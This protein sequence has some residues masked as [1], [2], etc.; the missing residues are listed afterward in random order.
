M[1]KK[2][3]GLFDRILIQALFLLLGLGIAQHSVSKVEFAEPQP[4]YIVDV[5][6]NLDRSDSET[7]RP[8]L[9]SAIPEWQVIDLEAPYCNMSRERFVPAFGD[10]PARIERADGSSKPLA[11]VIGDLLEPVG[12]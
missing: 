4:V 12:V 7:S 1:Q 8:V 3:D 10:H 6:P 11:P 2:P 5:R 9:A